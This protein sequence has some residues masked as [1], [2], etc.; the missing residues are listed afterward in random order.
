MCTVPFGGISSYCNNDNNW[1]P[2]A[3][4]FPIIGSGFDDFDC[5]ESKKYGLNGMIEFEENGS[6]SIESRYSREIIEKMKLTSIHIG[7]S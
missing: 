1:P 2:F 3:V 6:H 4:S 5:L 7:L